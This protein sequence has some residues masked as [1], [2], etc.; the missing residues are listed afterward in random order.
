L[1]NILGRAAATALSLEVL[2]ELSDRTAAAT[3]TTRRER[4][5]K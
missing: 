1:G 2:L 3:C 5:S 4:L